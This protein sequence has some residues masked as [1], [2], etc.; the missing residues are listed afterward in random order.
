MPKSQLV[1][2]SLIIFGI[3]VLAVAT[4]MPVLLPVRM[5][6]TEEQAIEQASAS[7]RLH[8]VTHQA[9]HTQESRTAS[10]ADK[11]Q[12]QQELAAA[13]ARYDA[14]RSSLD[15]AQF[16]NRTLP[17]ILRWT[18]GGV[19]LMGVLVYLSATGMRD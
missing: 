19:T 6:W 7:S 2:I 13:Q 12:A 11:L 16:W 15:R 1:A 3:T 4:L 17:S 14:S 18:G 8:Q 9:A 5:F 10:D